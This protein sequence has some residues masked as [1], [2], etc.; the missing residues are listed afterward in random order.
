MIR[1]W[2]TRQAC[3]SADDQTGSLEESFIVEANASLSVLVE[4]IVA[5]GFLQFTATHD[6]ITGEVDGNRLVEIYASRDKQPRFFV[7]SEKLVALV[8]G[9]RPLDFYFRHV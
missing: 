3:C 9:G 8:I 5:S 7:K 2:V 6:C 1:I 4:K